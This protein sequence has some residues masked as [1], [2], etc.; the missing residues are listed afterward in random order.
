MT[1]DPYIILGNAISGFLVG[2]G[3]RRAIPAP[4]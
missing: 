2:T 3:G 1:I 4:G